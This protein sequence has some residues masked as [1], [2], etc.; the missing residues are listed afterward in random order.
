MNILRHA[1]FYDVQHLDIIGQY[2]FRYRCRSVVSSSEARWSKVA[3]R[4]VATTLH[5][6]PAGILL[7]HS[8]L[9]DHY[10]V[11]WLPRS[12]R[13]HVPVWSVIASPHSDDLHFLANQS[14][15]LKAA[16]RGDLLSGPISLFIFTTGAFCRHERVFCCIIDI[17][18]T[19][20]F[21][22]YLT[23]IPLL[24]LWARYPHYMRLA[25]GSFVM[26]HWPTPFS[27]FA[28]MTYD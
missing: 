28:S 9:T 19:A 13:L 8:A 1:M 24:P 6:W 27:V 16:V 14:G 4:A 2:L 11:G 15:I 26:S 17:E 20:L 10:Y 5:T 12:F 18:A 23:K 21:L 7:P 25:I 22:Y 3:A